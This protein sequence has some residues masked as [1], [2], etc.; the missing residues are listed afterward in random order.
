MIMASNSPFAPKLG[1]NYVPETDTELAEIYGYVAKDVAA[2]TV[3]QREMSELQTKLDALQS[4]CHSLQASIDAHRALAS[5]FRR[6]PED[7]LREVFAFCMPDEPF[8]LID[9]KQAPL[10]LTHICAEWRQLAHSMPALWS[11]VHIHGPS[12]TSIPP[13]T[14]AFPPEVVLDWLEH[15]R[16]STMPVDLSV[17]FPCNIPDFW[18][19][20]MHRLRRLQLILEPGAGRQVDIQPFID[21]TAAELPQLSYLKLQSDRDRGP[22]FWP[23]ASILSLPTLRT[24]ALRI[25]ADPLR[26]PLPWAEL[27]SLKLICNFTATSIAAVFVGGLSVSDALDILGRCTNLRSADLRITRGS[28][29][30]QRPAVTMAALEELAISHGIF[31]PQ[32]LNQIVAPRLRKLMLEPKAGREDEDKTLLLRALEPHA[33]NLIAVDFIATLFSTDTLIAFFPLAPALRELI[34]RHTG[35]GRPPALVDHTALEQLTHLQCPLLERVEFVSC[36]AFNEWEFGAFLKARTPTLRTVVIDFDRPRLFDVLQR[37]PPEKAARLHLDLKYTDA[38]I[39][40][41]NPRARLD[42]L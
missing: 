32:F 22:Q 24:V 31:L 13:S 15:V 10:L 29:F 17:V 21:A 1:T 20:V 27:T 18:V 7:I 19:P 33:P 39:A 23:N 9:A 12:A 8:A 40:T 38:Y 16:H 34:L 42:D 6:V 30:Q 25:R 26:L 2:L 36:A 35:P 28:Q 11:A 41:Y 14:A 3:L 5:A 37:L 4:R